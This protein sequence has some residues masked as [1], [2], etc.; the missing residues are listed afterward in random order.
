M[1]CI[2]FGQEWSELNTRSKKLTRAN[3]SQTVDEIS[4]AA[5]I[6]HGTCH[7]ILSDDLN[8]SH[9]TQH[10]VPRILSQDKRD[11]LLNTFGD[12][13][14]LKLKQQS[15]T[16]KQKLQRNRSEGTVILE[17]FYNSSGLV[18]MELIPEGVTVNE[19]HYKDILHC[20][21]SSVCRKDPEFWR[22]MNWLLLHDNAPAHCSVLVQEELPKQC[23]TVLPRPLYSP[24][25]APCDFSCFPRLKEKLRGHQFQSAEEIVTAT[26]EAIQDIPAN[27]FQQCFQRPYQRWQTC[28]AA[29]GNCLREDVDS[30]CVWVSRSMVQP[31]TVYEIIDWS[32]CA[33]VLV[34]SGL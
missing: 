18:H 16:W 29:N 28:I 34:K 3:R 13:Y 27:I 30:K 26:R 9:V 1:M 19:H 20:L 7:R 4:A 25:L 32:S 33:S 23:F 11:Y 17:V 21:H 22:K 15:A 2:L 31:T 10:S 8:M 14:D 24:D 12:L 6:S 5:G